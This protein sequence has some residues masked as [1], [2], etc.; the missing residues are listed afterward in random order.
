MKRFILGLNVILL[1]AGMQNAMAAQV[2][3]DL[4][5]V[6]SGGV[7]TDSALSWGSVKLTDVAYNG[8]QAIQIDV[9]LAGSGIH[10]VLEV[11]L[12]YNDALFDN[13]AVFAL[14]SGA[15][16][17]VKENSIKLQSYDG[18]DLEPTTPNNENEPWVGILYRS[19]TDLGVGM[20]DF[21]GGANKLYAAVHIGNYGTAPGTGGDSSITVGAKGPGSPVPEPATML[22]FGTGLIGLAGIA[23]R[24][25]Q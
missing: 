15:G 9:D 6:I 8:R 20:F 1:L 4:N 22:L 14:S 17:D 25:V 18:F 23:R 12:N 10:K 13:T 3:W 19:G 11:A 7:C 21:T 16:V 5:C 2:Q 24:K